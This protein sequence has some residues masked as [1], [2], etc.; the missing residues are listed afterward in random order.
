M[1]D[2]HWSEGLFGYFPTY[3]LGNLYSAAIRDAMAQDLAIDDLVRAGEFAPILTWLR[4]R[5]HAVGAALGQAG[6]AQIGGHVPVQRI[7]GNRRLGRGHH[8]RRRRRGGPG[9]ATGYRD[10]QGNGT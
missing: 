5:I 8:G 6:Q 7:G 2:I 4:E 9:R 1:Q 3:T 10:S